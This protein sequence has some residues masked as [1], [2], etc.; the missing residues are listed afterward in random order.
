M[1]RKGDGLV[2]LAED[3]DTYEAAETAFAVD[4]RKAPDVQASVSEPEEIMFCGWRR[5]MQDTITVWRPPFS[6]PPF[7]L[8]PAPPPSVL[9]LAFTLSHTLFS[10]C[11][12]CLSSACLPHGCLP[13]DLINSP[14]RH[15]SLQA[16]DEMVSPGSVLH[17]LCEREPQ[18]MRA[19]LAEFIDLPP[20]SR[21]LAAAR[22]AV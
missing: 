21:Q 20:L 6:L 9:F 11:P 4:Q 10:C 12:L 2:V 19:A 22:S 14:Y 7:L 1:L 8:A 13:C 16:L 5:D 18:E 3:D 15:V 17:I